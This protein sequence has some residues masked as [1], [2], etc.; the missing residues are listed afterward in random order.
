MLVQALWAFRQINPNPKLTFLLRNLRVNELIL[1]QVLRSKP[2]MSVL[3]S[4]AMQE[5]SVRSQLLPKCSARCRWVPDWV[6]CT[7]WLPTGLVPFL[8]HIL[9]PFQWA[10]Y[11][12]SPPPPLLSALSGHQTQM[13][14]IRCSINQRLTNYGPQP[15]MYPLL[16]FVKS[17]IM[18]TALRLSVWALSLAGFAPQ[19]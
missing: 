16:G 18:W 5:A 13:W 9:Q 6:R 3:W 15:Q 19:K 8:A 1:P 2:G 17:N 12:G 4:K 14:P 11:L 7:P 10:T